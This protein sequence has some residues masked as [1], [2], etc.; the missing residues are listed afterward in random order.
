MAVESNVQV[1]SRPA[2]ADLSAS[3]SRFATLSAGKVAICSTQ[4]EVSVGV[5]GDDPPSAADQA[6]E[7][8]HAGIVR[9]VA[10]A[11]VA[12]LA[13]VTTD[14]TGRAIL[15]TTGNR[16]HGQALEAASAAGEVIE[17]LLALNGETS[18]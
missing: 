7:L 14:T 17:V 2:S 10:G 8:K 11:A 15:A 3:P 6:C 12:A 16:I 18:A 4:G 5:T 9:I 13:N 1:Y